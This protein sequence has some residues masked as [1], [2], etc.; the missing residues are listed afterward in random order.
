MRIPLIAGNWKMH[1]MVRESV[2]FAKDLWELI[3]D[4]KDREVL[5]C[6]PFTSL[7]AVRQAIEGTTIKLGAQNLNWEDAG[8]FTGAIAPPM[9]VDVGCEYVIIGHSERRK[10]WGNS[11]E[12]VN[13]K[14]HAAI[15][16]GLK[17]IMCVGETLE[18]KEADLTRQVV[19]TQVEVGLK[20]LTASELKDL[21]IAYE[22]VWAI[23]TGKNDDPAQANKTI[24]FIR[25]VLGSRFGHNFSQKI[26]ILYGGSVKPD[27]VDG[28]M[29][30]SDIDGTLV[31]GASL[32]VESFA[33]IVKF[34]YEEANQD[35]HR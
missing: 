18:E 26:R 16:S 30:M 1:M 2:N 19:G 8:A 17:P 4:T 15:R 31:G 7:Y 10:I 29:N 27:N 22:P 5:V 21:V 11:N 25:D 6:P 24:S 3:K 35:V 14:A 28:F 34:K 32:K 12:D 20:D 9:L 13:K 33:R 23:G